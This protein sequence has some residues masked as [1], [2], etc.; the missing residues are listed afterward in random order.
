MS[1]PQINTLLFPENLGM[2]YHKVIHVPV[3][4]SYIIGHTAGAVGN[5]LGLFKDCDLQ[6][7]EVSLS[8]A[9]SA[10]SYCVSTNDYKFHG[11]SP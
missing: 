10:H 3:W 9:C 4:I 7:G 6:V 8:A 1:C 11:K 2:A 5:V